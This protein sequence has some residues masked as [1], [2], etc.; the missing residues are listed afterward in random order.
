MFLDVLVQECVLGHP[1]HPRQDESSS[2][3]VPVHGAVALH[4]EVLR[5]GVLCS[6]DTIQE[7]E[8]EREAIM[9]VL[10]EPVPGWVPHGL[11]G[12]VVQVLVP[13]GQQ[14]EHVGSD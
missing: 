4:S 3:V 2:E 7:V 8:A 13:L 10:I 5:R 14:V 1:P 9:I 6:Q 12:E 11:L